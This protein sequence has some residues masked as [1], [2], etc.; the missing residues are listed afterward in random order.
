MV[1][2]LL[3]SALVG[4]GTGRSR[5]LNKDA[6]LRKPE[7]LPHAH[8]PE[9]RAQSEANHGAGGAERGNSTTA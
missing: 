2:G 4:P 8:G 6:L 3:K 1:R 7:A 9:M 5:S